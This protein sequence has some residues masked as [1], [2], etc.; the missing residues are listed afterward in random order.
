LVLNRKMEFLD[1]SDDTYG[2]HTHTHP[3]QTQL[4][5]GQG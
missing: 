3:C 5:M 1:D 4:R 2:W